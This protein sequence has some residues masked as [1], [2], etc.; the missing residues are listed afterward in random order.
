MLNTSSFTHFARLT[1]FNKLRSGLVCG[2]TPFGLYIS[3]SA[4][5][6][7]AFAI[8]LLV[9][10]FV[11]TLPWGHLKRDVSQYSLCD[12]FGEWNEHWHN[13]T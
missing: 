5:I 11:S 12:R 1:V 3:I 7:P 6:S 10:V 13:L 9:A 8:F 4:C 2:E